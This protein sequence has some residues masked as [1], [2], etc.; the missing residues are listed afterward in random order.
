MQPE[1]LIL[2]APM[3][4]SSC[5]WSNRVAI[6]WAMGME[7]AVAL[8]A[9]Q[10]RAYPHSHLAFRATFSYPCQERFNRLPG[11]VSIIASQS[12][13]LEATRACSEATPAGRFVEALEIT[14]GVFEEGAGAITVKIDA[15]L[16]TMEGA[17]RER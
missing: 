13:L 15:A 14:R 3:S 10:L 9:E 17:Q 11:P 4:C 12:G 16:E 6:S 7:R 2:S 5:S 8:L 1:I